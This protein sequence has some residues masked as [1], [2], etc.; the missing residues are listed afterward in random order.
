MWLHPTVCRSF[1]QFTFQTF[2]TFSSPL[3]A[4]V[5]VF[6]L[7]PGPGGFPKEGEAGFDARIKP[8]TP[9]VDDAAQVL[10]TEMFYEF[11]KDHFQCFSMKRIF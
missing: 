9:D 4:D 10:P 11:G 1:Y 6:H 2:Q 7:L 3:Y 5:K 8:E